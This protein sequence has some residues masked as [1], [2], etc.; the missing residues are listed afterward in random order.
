MTE[1]ISVNEIIPILNE[2][3]RKS[4]IISSLSDIQ[5]GL[6]VDIIEGLK[7]IGGYNQG[8]KQRINFIQKQNK[9]FREEVNS[10]YKDKP[11]MVENFGEITDMMKEFLY[12]IIE[13]KKNDAS[14]DSA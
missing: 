2:I 1:K 3:R 7:K 8:L 6:A 4:T 13:Y 5:E 12:E 10:R 14:R 9:M 11:D